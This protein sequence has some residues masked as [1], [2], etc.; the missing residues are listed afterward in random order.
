MGD[1]VKY[2]IEKARETLRSALEIGAMHEDIWTLS[3]IASALGTV[4][5][6]LASEA[7]KDYSLKNP[8]YNGY[9]GTGISDDVITFK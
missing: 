6:L 4:E 1:S 7:Q 3:Q 9:V 2:Q 5:G 8:Y